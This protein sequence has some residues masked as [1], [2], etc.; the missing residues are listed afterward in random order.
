MKH[1]IKQLNQP[2]PP[3]LTT[4]LLALGG[5]VLYALVCVPLYQLFGPGA[6]AFV[7][8]PALALAW[9]LGVRWGLLGAL[10]LIELTRQLLLWSHVGPLDGMLAELLPGAICMLLLVL[11]MGSLRDHL[12]LLTAR[13]ALQTRERGQ[14]KEQLAAAQAAG[15]DLQ[16]QLSA[17]RT[18]GLQRAQALQ[19]QLAVGRSLAQEY[20]AELRTLWA[21]TRQ[22]SEDLRA[23]LQRAQALEA[24]LAAAPAAAPPAPIVPICASCKKIHDGHGCWSAPEAY[25][26]E[27]MGLRFSHGVCPDCT[28]ALYPDL[29]TPDAGAPAP[30]LLERVG[31]LL[32]DNS[33]RPELIASALCAWMAAHQAD[34]VALAGLL[35]C[36]V[37]ALVPLATCLRPQQG[38]HRDADLELIAAC[39]DASSAALQLLLD[40][41]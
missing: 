9:L 18:A 19:D 15:Q 38:R 5:V 17:E 27:T 34:L 2:L 8:V 32:A 21:N 11:G 37:E 33:H 39:V 35:G 16:R 3:W 12:R 14:L 29:Y 24:Q 40:E 26:H 13:A 30:D 41:A 25:L 36:T 28:R 23:A 31:Q 10:L 7:Y 22:R 4:S 20:E 6:L 1:Y